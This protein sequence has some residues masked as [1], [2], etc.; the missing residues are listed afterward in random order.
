M[1]NGTARVLFEVITGSIA[2]AQVRKGYGP[3]LG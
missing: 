1:D 2:Q 3:R